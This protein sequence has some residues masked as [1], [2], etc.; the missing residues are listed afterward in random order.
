MFA[1]REKNRAKKTGRKPG[2]QKKNR[3][4]MVLRPVFRFHARF[5]GALFF[6]LSPPPHLWRFLLSILRYTTDLLA[7]RSLIQLELVIILVLVLY[8]YVVLVRR[9]G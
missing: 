3:A 5:F 2:R 8:S 9:L 4:I 7:Q 6:T 1:L